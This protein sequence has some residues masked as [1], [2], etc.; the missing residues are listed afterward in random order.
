[1]E[2]TDRI[3]IIDGVKA[4]ICWPRR[5]WKT[6]ARVVNGSWRCILCNFKLATGFLSESAVTRHY[7]LEHAQK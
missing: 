5:G 7:A 4:N 6:V 1:M 2:R 3:R